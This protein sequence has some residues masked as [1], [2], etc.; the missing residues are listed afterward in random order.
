MKLKINTGPPDYQ[1]RC[2]HGWHGRVKEVLKITL[3]ILA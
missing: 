2:H 3:S 1:M